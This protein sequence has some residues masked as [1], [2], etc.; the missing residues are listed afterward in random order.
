[1]P[2]GAPR[3]KY[4]ESVRKAVEDLLGAG[5][6]PCE[7]KHNLQVSHSWVC[8]LEKLKQAF[9]TTITSPGEE[10]GLCRTT[11]LVR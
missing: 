4:H 6:R 11:D 2:S 1:M 3:P 9:G 8:E 5:A 10:D 7:I